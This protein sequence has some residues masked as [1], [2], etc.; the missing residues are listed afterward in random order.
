MIHIRFAQKEDIEG[1]INFLRKH[2]NGSSILVRAGK[3]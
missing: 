3:F 1:I 2:W